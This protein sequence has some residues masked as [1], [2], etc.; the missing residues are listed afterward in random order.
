MP[1]AEPAKAREPLILLPRDFIATL[2]A[3]LS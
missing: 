3:T 2:L 1:I